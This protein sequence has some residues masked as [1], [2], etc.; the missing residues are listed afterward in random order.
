MKHLF[1][2]AASALLIAMSLCSCSDDNDD[3]RPIIDPVDPGRP[4]GAYLLNQGSYYSNIAGTIGYLDYPSQ[5]LTDSLFYTL[6]GILPGNTLQYGLFHGSRFYFIAYESNALFVC[7]HLLHLQKII[8]TDHPRALAAD[9][10]HLYVSSYDGYVFRLD[11]LSLSVADT[12]A[13]GPNPE[14][15][16][17]AGGYLYVANSDGL[18]YANNYADGKSV[19]KI[20]LSTFTLEKNIPVGLNPTRMAA[21]SEG[22][23]YVIASGDY[24]STPSVLQKID[25]S[26]HVTDIAQ[27]T[28]MTLSL[29]TIYAVNSV[30]DWTTYETSNSYFSISTRS[31]ERNDHLVSEGVEWPIMI[32]VDPKSRHLFVSSFTTGAYGASY[33][34]SGYLREY[35]PSGIPLR[36]YTTGVNP[37]QLV[38][39]P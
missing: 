32:A 10:A 28:M 34:T 13:V 2:K 35:S 26:D 25:P 21:D 22:N 8:R 23:V 7:D 27:A 6:N 36:T 18:N 16:A 38:F 20:R 1:L 15:M 5:T 12:V 4:A 29:D 11:T 9:G 39:T 33:A 19:S 37:V 17:I 31:L 3:P 30:T 14:E 24:G